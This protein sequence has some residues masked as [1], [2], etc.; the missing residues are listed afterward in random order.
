MAG[1]IVTAGNG[2]WAE[3]GLRLAYFGGAARLAELRRKPVGLILKFERVRPRRGDRFQPLRCHE[4]TPEFLERA[5]KALRRWN[6]DVVSLDEAIAR[7]RDPGSAGRF[8]CLS[9]DGGYRD[10]M[11][12][13]YPVLSR[14]RVPFT[15]YLP[16]AFMDGLGEAWWLALEQVIAR[17]DR[18]AMMI[19]YTERRFEI[20]DTAAKHQLYRFLGDWMHSLAPA[21]LSAV[22]HDLCKRYSVDLAKLSREAAMGWD[23]V[24]QLAADPLVT[25]GTAT[26]NHPVLANLNDN[27]AIKEITMGRAVARAAL[28][29]DVP[30]FAF[31]FGDAK[32]F[33]A[34][35]VRL[36]QDAGFASAVTALPGVLDARRPPDLLRLPRLA[37]D[38]RRRSIRPL[39]VLLSGLM[40]GA[41]GHLALR[42]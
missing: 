23:E 22:I 5:I 14:H 8:V 11:T 31:P 7:L 35:Q 32:S 30:H 16:T 39:R 1:A 24:G 33:N 40:P 21:E 28:G 15:V 34:N 27:A 9:F 6:C 17:T 3:A 20:A 4:I 13:G 10:L 18:I 2:F 29:R 25:I 19:E 41:A 36:L 37:W 26:V 12:F 42:D 38:G